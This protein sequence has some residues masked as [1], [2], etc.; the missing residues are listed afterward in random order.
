MAWSGRLPIPDSARG[1]RPPKKTALTSDL[2]DLWN[3]SFFLPRGVEAVLYK[4]RERRSGSHT[5]TIDRNLPSYGYDDSDSDSDSEDS[6]SDDSDD[7]S[8]DGRYRSVGYGVHGGQAT[9]PMSESG[10]HKERNREKKRRHKE[11]KARKKAKARE[12]K[13][14][15]YLTCVP[16]RDPGVVP[17]TMP[18]VMPGGY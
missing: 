4:G 12:T 8:D 11:R 16:L 17:G 7:S 13:Y 3:A 10:R 14:A 5:G 9:G 18:G 6:D 15:L 1:G 2:L